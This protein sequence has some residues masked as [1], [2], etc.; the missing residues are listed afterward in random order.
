MLIN[1]GKKLDEHGLRDYKSITIE[2]EKK[3]FE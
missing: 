2:G 1:C 3:V